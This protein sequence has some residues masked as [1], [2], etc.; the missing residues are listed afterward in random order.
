NNY[1]IGTRFVA[2]IPTIPSPNDYYT[3]K[4]LYVLNKREDYSQELETIALN[5]GFQTSNTKKELEQIASIPQKVTPA[6]IKDRLDLR[7]ENIFTIDGS[8]TKD[9]DDAVSINSL[10]NG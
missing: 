2:Y 6:E 1:P 4:P 8:H 9:M 5:N 7:S 10:P 3:I